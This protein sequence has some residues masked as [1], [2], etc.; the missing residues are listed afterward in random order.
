MTPRFFLQVF[1]KNNLI[2]NIF[3][4]EKSLIVEHNFFLKKLVKIRKEDLNAFSTASLR[5]RKFKISCCDFYLCWCFQ[6]KKLSEI[7]TV[8]LNYGEIP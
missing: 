5:N 2:K 6:L 3:E 1:A 8:Q 7:T 4:E